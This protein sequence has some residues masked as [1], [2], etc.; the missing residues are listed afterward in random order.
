MSER[1]EI[2]RTRLIA[3][4]TDLNATG[5]T[6]VALRRTVGDLAFR[7]YSDGRARDWADLKE[8]ADAKTYDSLLNLFQKHSE[9]AARNGDQT[10]VRA[11]ELL[12][13]SLIARRQHQDDLVA[14]VQ[15]LDDYIANAA[16]AVSKGRFHLPR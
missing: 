12:G 7:L 11:T 8:R 10:T 9:E 4:M 14:G 3:V 2:F 13:L 6:D 16:A 5:T 1:G 15:A